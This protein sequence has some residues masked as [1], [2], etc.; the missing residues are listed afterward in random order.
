MYS[1]LCC[2]PQACACT[3]IHSL[4][5]LTQNASKNTQGPTQIMY[6]EYN[7]K[8][9]SVSGV[10]WNVRYMRWVQMVR[11]THNNTKNILRVA[12]IPEL[13]PELRNL[14]SAICS[15][16]N[17][18]KRCI[19]TLSVTDRAYLRS[20][21]SCDEGSGTNIGTSNICLEGQTHYSD[22]LYLPCLKCFEKNHNHPPISTD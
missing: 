13:T 3:Y 20:F 8:N 4:S 17:I 11:Y 19:M 10:H 14:L 18:Y 15:T 12:S 1:W 2:I 5:C 6:L 7:T 9:N 21:W 22:Q 16:T